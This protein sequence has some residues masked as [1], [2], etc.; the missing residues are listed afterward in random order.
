[1][2]PRTLI[3]AKLQVFASACRHGALSIDVVMDV[4]KTGLK[5]KHIDTW[6]K[7]T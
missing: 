6:K 3:F 7:L 4:V 1:M 5:L 2:G